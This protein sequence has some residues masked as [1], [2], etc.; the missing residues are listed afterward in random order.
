MKDINDIP[1]PS[2]AKQRMEY[3]QGGDRP[4]NEFK[5]N[6]SGVMGFLNSLNPLQ[7]ASETIVQLAHYKY[8]IKVLETEQR[9]ID[10][11]VHLRHQQIDADLTLALQILDDRRST[12]HLSLEGT[13][14]DLEQVH[15]E[16]KRIID[17]IDN[18][19]ANISNPT[20]SSE[21]KQLSYATMTILTDSL[22]VMGEQ[23]S[24]KL[25]VIAKNTQK[26]LEAMPNINLS[27]TFKRE[28]I[29]YLS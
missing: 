22:K 20:L 14:K 1:Q 23:S 21:E 2:I 15:I 12:L 7:L 26:A 18:L 28:C 25:D 5:L 4:D 13:L 11:E 17:C 27:L 16:K 6:K 19:I 3:I 24:V 9:R 29:C 10:G 8:R